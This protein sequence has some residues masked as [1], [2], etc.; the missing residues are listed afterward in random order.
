MFKTHRA[1][2]SLMHALII[3]PEP[4]T[5]QLIEDCLSDLGFT[6]FDFAVDEDY[7]VT[8]AVTRCP[9]LITADVT[10]AGGCGITAVQRICNAAP[11][12]VVYVTATSSEV[13]GRSSGAT[14]VRKPFSIDELT[15]G[16]GQA[17]RAA[18]A[19]RGKF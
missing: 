5:A 10:L 12:P 7:A 2:R 6:S 17:R 18:A 3:E 1:G 15:Y 13:R 4:F 16:V 8:C 9:D 11:I 14:I 19:A